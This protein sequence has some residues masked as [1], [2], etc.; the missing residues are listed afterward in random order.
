MQQG[1]EKEKKKKNLLYHEHIK[2]SFYEVDD[3]LWA[4]ALSQ[5]QTPF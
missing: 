2:I 4:H 3:Y 1:Q 5:N